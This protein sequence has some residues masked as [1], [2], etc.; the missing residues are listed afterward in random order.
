MLAMGFALPA[1][2]ANIVVD[3]NVPDVNPDG[4]CSLIEAID[5]ANA[6]AAVHADCAAGSGADV[7]TLAPSSVHTITSAILPGQGLPTITSQMTIGGN[8]ATLSVAPVPVDQVIDVAATGDLTLSNATITGDDGSGTHASLP[9]VRNAGILHLNNTA[10]LLNQGVGGLL[11]LPSGL[12]QADQLTVD[13]GPGMVRS[14]TY[15]AGTGILNQGEMHLSN[16]KV[17]NLWFYNYTF[18]VAYGLANAVPLRNEGNMTLTEV[19]I[20]HNT[21]S[22]SYYWGSAFH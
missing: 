15:S 13:A 2:A 1:Q 17:Q 6:D 21:D 5:N 7:I 22:G 9:R 11:N 4:Y 18:N 10:I 8:G 14:Y 3:I 19:A 12:V 16:S 20:F